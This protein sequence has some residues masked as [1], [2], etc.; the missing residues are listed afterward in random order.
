MTLSGNNVYA[1]IFVSFFFYILRIFL[2]KFYAKK[3]AF[4][5]HLLSHVFNC[6]EIPI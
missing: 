2:C 4:S 3:F 1:I 6:N 5:T